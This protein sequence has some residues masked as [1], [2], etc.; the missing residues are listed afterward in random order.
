MKIVVVGANGFLARNLVQKLEIHYEVFSFVRSRPLDKVKDSRIFETKD[1]SKI[2]SK[3]LS[4]KPDLI[5]NLAS[6]YS[7]KHHYEGI[8][9][10]INTEINLSAHLADICCELGINL[11]Q[12]KS[13]FQKSEKNSGINLYAASKNARDEL[14]QYF[15][16]FNQLN[17]I[18][19][20]LGDVYGYADSRNKLIPSVIAH[21]EAGNNSNFILENPERKFYPIYLEDVLYIMETAIK[22]IEAGLMKSGDVQCFDRDGMTLKNFVDKVQ[23]IVPKDRFNVSWLHQSTEFRETELVVPS[24]LISLVSKLTPFEIG[25]RSV[26]NMSNIK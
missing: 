19:I 25:F 20:L 11:M 23:T 21:I 9:T 18:N 26:L 15:V 8:K 3:M 24:D 12:T 16:A 7:V 14:M 13:L 22:K 1:F 17:L 4:I 6:D 5:I 2:R 10:I